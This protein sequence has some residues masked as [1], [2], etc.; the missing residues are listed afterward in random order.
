MGKMN[1]SVPNASARYRRAPEPLPRSA[2]RQDARPG[3]NPPSSGSSKRVSP[4]SRRV[5]DDPSRMRPR[6]LPPNRHIGP[7]ETLPRKKVVGTPGRVAEVAKDLQKRK[8]GPEQ[9]QSPPSKKSKSV[10]FSWNFTHSSGWTRGLAPSYFGRST[11][12]KVVFLQ[13]RR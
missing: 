8:D 7:E 1:L 6:S 9:E 10:D 11:L 5:V 2:P 12:V 4:S 3:A 13:L